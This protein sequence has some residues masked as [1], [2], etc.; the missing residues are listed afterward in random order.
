MA[1]RFHALYHNRPEASIASSEYSHS[2]FAMSPVV[3]TSLP[4]DS[5]GPGGDGGGGAPGNASF[6]MLFSPAASSLASTPGGPLN[7]HNND[8]N[9]Q[10]ELEVDWDP[11]LVHTELLQASAI[12]SHRGLKLAAKWAAEQLVGIATTTKAAAAAAGPTHKPTTAIPQMHQLQ[13]SAW[14]TLTGADWYAKSLFDLGEYLH[15]AYVLSDT[16][17]QSTTGTASMDMLQLPG[18]A[19]NLSSYGCYLRAYALYMA[20]ERRKEEDY[21]ELQ[22]YD[23]VTVAATGPTTCKW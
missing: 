23:T 2:T 3:T 4:F 14:S 13:E 20:G 22:R 21:L 7:N 16:T 9:A 12:L 18:P 1:P 6:S 17:T 8:T 5:H 19:P 10:V 15:A 11:A